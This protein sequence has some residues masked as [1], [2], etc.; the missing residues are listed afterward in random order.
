MRLQITGLVSLIGCHFAADPRLNCEDAQRW[1]LE[2]KQRILLACYN[3]GLTL[4]LAGSLNVSTGMSEAD[5]D[6][7]FA[8]IQTALME[9]KRDC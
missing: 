3:Q 8:K 9:V 1:P 7:S 5:I 6:R 4:S 2:S